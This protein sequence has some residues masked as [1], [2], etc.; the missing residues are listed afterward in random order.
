[1]DYAFRRNV[2]ATIPALRRYARALTRNADI[3]DDLVHDTLV[4]I[5]RSEHL[6]HSSNARSRLYKILINLNRN[7]LRR[8]SRQ[9]LLPLPGDNDA[10]DL[11]RPQAENR[12]IERALAALVEDQ[13]NALLL[14]VLE[15][16]TYHQVAEVQGVS[17][18]TVISRLARA[19]VEIEKY[20]V[21]DRPALTNIGPSSSR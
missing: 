20:L 11:T 18:G 1:M 16:L 5:L 12:D 2:E 8:L 13:R 21:S 9:A 15:G 14:V 19:R 6:F 3:A 4:R 7:R 17:V 10:L